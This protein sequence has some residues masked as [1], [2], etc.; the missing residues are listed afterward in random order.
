MNRF[1][2]LLIANRGEIAIRIARAA[3]DL[4]LQ[5]VSIY[6]EEDATSLHR[7]RTDEAIALNAKGADAYLDID[8]IVS[9]AKA[10]QCDAVHPGYGFLSE[11]A[12]FA[13]ALS[14]EG[15]VFV[16]PS[17]DVLEKLGDKVSARQIAKGSGVP[18]L[19]GTNNEISLEQ[20]VTFFES[21]PQGESM[22][23]K[24]VAGGGG[25]GMRVVTSGDEIEDAYARCAS[26]A[27]AAF[28]NDALYAEHFYQGGRHIEVQIVGDEHGN[29]NHLWE[30]ECTLQRRHQ[31]LIEVAPSPTLT[32]E[33]RQQ[34]LD[35]A[36]KL[37]SHLDYANLGTVE[38]LVSPENKSMPF[39]FIEV[40]PRLQVEHTVTEIITDVDLVRTQLLIAMG[41]SLEQLEL[42]QATCK[43]RGSAIQLRINME[44]MESDGSAKPAGGKLDVFELPNGPDVRVDTYGYTG[45]VTSPAFDSLLAKVIT[46]DV[47][48]DWPALLKKAKRVLAEI[49]VSIPT[50][51]DFITSLLA[52]PNVIAND[53]DTRFVETHIAELMDAMVTTG[54]QIGIPESTD[55]AE[56]TTQ[57]G[58]TDDTI[59]DGCIPIL[60]PMQGSVI[61]IEAEVGSDLTEGETVLIMESM[62]MEHV[63]ES[64]ADGV[65][66][67]MKVGLDDTVFEGA[68]IG[69]IK[70]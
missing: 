21:L 14:S 61:E 29:I 57:V 48:G 25:R 26:E 41:Q 12:E 36:L 70:V 7:Y 59:P 54:H 13:D 9:I 20:A 63:I 17:P 22:I 49:R 24:A 52:H 58:L 33:L 15:V 30:R 67:E 66:Q 35:A 60:A 27:K 10:N 53:I 40:N 3:A 68:V 1:N 47:K 5:T 28:G 11:N 37:G 56:A 39:A 16:G 38:F 50:N 46:R 2:K 23:I 51:K 32:D 43:P 44:T 31:K 55:A 4:G 18:V 34:I 65:L 8:K 42:A 64:P 45:Y 62:K 19:D 69:F 6:S